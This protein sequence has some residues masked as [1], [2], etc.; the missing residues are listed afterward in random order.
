MNSLGEPFQYSPFVL[1]NDEIRLLTIDRKRKDAIVYTLGICWARSQFYNAL[2]YTWGDGDVKMPIILNEK[3]FFVTSNLAS[4]LTALRDY[5]GRRYYWIDA[6]CI[7]QQDPAERNCQVRRMKDIHQWANMV[8]IWLG[9]DHEVEDE[10]H[11][12][13]QNIWGFTSLET[14]TSDSTMDAFLT[15][16][17]LADF[18]RKQ[19][20]SHLSSMYLHQRPIATWASVSRILRRGWFDRL[21]VIQECEAAQAAVV[22]C[23]MHE[24]AWDDLELAMS[25]ILRPSADV[26]IVYCSYFRS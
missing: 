15:V 4:A 21:W 22:K 19:E 24:I 12:Y 9:L 2:S 18:Q 8:I 11:Y 7:N 1:P 3:V 26:L 10:Q 23:G 5:D 6:I 17:H 14:G 13:R 16:T 20:L 25:Y